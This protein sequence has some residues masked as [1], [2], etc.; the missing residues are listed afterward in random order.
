MH[1]YRLNCGKNVS[2]EICRYYKVHFITKSYEH[3]I[4]TDDGINVSIIAECLNIRVDTMNCDT[5]RDDTMNCDTIRDDTMNCDTI[6]DD[7]M[8]CDTMRRCNA[9]DVVMYLITM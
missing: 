8:N 2:C 3:N 4:K 5:I 1:E 9:N 6:R 7:T